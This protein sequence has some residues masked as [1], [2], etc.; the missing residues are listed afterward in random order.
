MATSSNDLDR[1][2]LCQPIGTLTCPIQD[3][4]L[5]GP[6]P[7]ASLVAHGVIQLLPNP[8]LKLALNDLEGFSRIWLIWWFHRNDHWRPMVL[9]PRGRGG[10]RGLFATRSPHRPNPIG[11]T[12]VPLLKVEGR[13]LYIGPHDLLNDTPIL[14]I[15]PYLSTV[16]AFTQETQG[17]LSIPTTNPTPYRLAYTELAQAQ[18]LWLVEHHQPT[19]THRVEQILRNDPF[20]H[21]TRRILK[22]PDGY[23]LS[24]GAW[25]I[26]FQIEEGTVKILYVE[27]KGFQPAHH[28][29]AMLHQAFLEMTQAFN[30]KNET[31]ANTSSSQKGH[32]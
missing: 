28:S 32:T 22:L 7:D 3:K 17:W 12:S 5:L 6:Q 9:P 31:P 27:S 15:K 11:L 20:P 19:F 25:R 8:N 10:R 29:Q 26:F 14:D 18:F 24:L 13:N 23:R 1:G 30:K 21:R 4:G 2:F 16:D